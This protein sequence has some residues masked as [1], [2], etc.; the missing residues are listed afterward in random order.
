MFIVYC[1]SS[2]Q[3]VAIPLSSFLEADISLIS[4]TLLSVVFFIDFWILCDILQLKKV[5]CLV[6]TMI[7]NVRLSDGGSI[8][9]YE[10]L[11][12]ETI[13]DENVYHTNSTQFLEGSN[14]STLSWNF[15]LTSDLSFGS[16]KLKL[17][18]VSIAGALWSGQHGVLDGFKKRF[19]ISWIPIQRVTLVIFNVTTNEDGIYACEVSTTE[20]LVSK[21]W[22]S[23]IEVDVVGKLLN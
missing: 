15:S 12:L 19:D 3:W 20:G 5:F 7:I 23:K 1:C 4:L 22:K 10:P 18:G 14:H 13:V 6:L 11:P 8:T 9:W 17:N 21:V 16:L 2:H